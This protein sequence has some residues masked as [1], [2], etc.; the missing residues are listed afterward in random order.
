MGQNSGYL[1][2][3]EEAK[4]PSGEKILRLIPDPLDSRLCTDDVFGL[5]SQVRPHFY[6]GQRLTHT[7]IRAHQVHQLNWPSGKN[8]CFGRVAYDILTSSR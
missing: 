5:S 8:R 2:G 1:Q 7:A 3:R 6:V 4:N